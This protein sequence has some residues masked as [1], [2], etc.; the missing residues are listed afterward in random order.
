MNSI[1]HHTQ[2]LWHNNTVFMMSHRL[3]S[4]QHTHSIWHHILYTC[5]I[6]ASV[7]MTRHLLCLWHHTQYIWYLTWCT[8]TI[9]PQ[10]QTSHSLYLCN[11]THLIDDITP[12]VC[13]KSHPLHVGH[14]R[15]YIWHHILFWW[16]HT[17]VY[18]SW[19]PLCL[20]HHIRYI[21]CHTH[22]VYDYPR[23]ISD[24]KPVQTAISSTIYVI[25]PSLSKPSHLLCQTSQV[26]YVCLH[27]R[28]TWHHIHTLWQKPLLFMT[29]HALYS[30][31]H[32]HYIWHLIYSVWC[33]IYYVCYITQWLYLWHQTLY[34]YAIF[35]LYGIMHSVMSTEPLCAFT[36]TIPDITLNIFLTL[37]TM[38]QCYEKK[39][40]YVITASICMTPYALHMTSHPLFMTSYH[41]IYDVKS[42]ISNITSTLSDLTSTV[43]V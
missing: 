39:C 27:M 41:F 35:S 15:H 7:S 24:L 6:T 34:V 19:H 9:Q 42:S 40:M 43:S 13:M 37:H 17:I 5:D 1:W 10:Y 38:Y 11:Y 32:T 18:M 21:W 8:M 26:A 29:S 22:C 16:H 20:W 33:H 30:L 3:Y 2:F 36:A 28:Y 23:S 31:H 12:Y 25:T 14:H 4:W